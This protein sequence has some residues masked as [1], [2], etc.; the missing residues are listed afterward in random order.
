VNK[1]IKC[2]AGHTKSVSLCYI[3][4]IPVITQPILS[5]S[6]NRCVNVLGSSNLSCPQ[7]PS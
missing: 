7:Q 4:I 5:V 1:V 3:P 2:T 6:E